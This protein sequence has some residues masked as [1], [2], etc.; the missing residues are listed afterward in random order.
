MFVCA[1]LVRLLYLLSLRH[2]YFFTLLLTEPRRYAEWAAAIV[3]GTARGLPPFDE[4]PASPYLLA[5]VRKGFGSAVA[6]AAG[7]QAVFDAA[8]CA[9]M[10]I[11]GRRLAGPRAGWI[12]GVLGALYG[13]LIYFCGELVP[14]TTL[15]FAIATAVV[16]TPDAVDRPRRWI[17]AGV[18]WSATLLVRTEAAL[19]LPLVMIHA[20]RHGGRRALQQIAAAPLLLVAASLAVNVIVSGHWVPMTTGG[21]V[22]LW[23]GNNPVAD[24]V[25]PF[26]HGSLNETVAEVNALAHDPADADVLFAA[27]AA[28]FW[29]SRPAAAVRLL[30]RKIAW[31]LTDRELPNTTDIDWETSQSWMFYSPWFPLHFGVLLPLALA[32][33][34][35]NLRAGRDLTLLATGAAIA[36]GTS[37]IFFTN[38]RFRLVLVL[39]LVPLAAHALDR[40]ASLWRDRRIER[41]ALVGALS[42]VAVG[43]VV[44]GANVDGVRQYAVP[45]IAVNVGALE[46]AAGDSPAAV[47]HLEAALRADSEDAAGWIQLALAYEESGQVERARATWQSNRARWP[48]EPLVQQMIERFER[49]NPKPVSPK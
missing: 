9:A 46:R 33:A 38:A 44:A 47:R 35:L 3:D 17:L 24:G 29:R 40:A 2:A 13:P 25:N 21:G 12:A 26:I 18:L 36:F 45:Q 5:A 49:R 41:G 22:N 16:A 14:A 7:A 27:R 10:A 8:S 34:F 42:A 4:A 15:V 31:T 32:G 28:E 19:A 37:A 1:L 30:V 23:L 43:T 6:T 20:F 39:T 48:D 11:L